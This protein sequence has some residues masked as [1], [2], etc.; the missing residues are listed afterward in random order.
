ME[1]DKENS[2]PSLRNAESLQPENVFKSAEVLKYAVAADFIPTLKKCVNDNAA[3]S[4][5]QQAFANGKVKTITDMQ[6]LTPLHIVVHRNYLLSTGWL[7]DHGAD[8]SASEDL[9]FTPLMVAAGSG[10]EEALKTVL[11]KCQGIV[12]VDARSTEGLT[13][14]HLACTNGHANCLEAL[15]SVGGAEG[16]SKC[17]RGDTPMHMSASRGFTSC[18]KILLVRI[19]SVCRP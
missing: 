16:I 6:G 11:R 1:I 19:C 14:V 13:A 17:V 10:S 15:L 3:L 4:L 12:D 8:V 7:L 18:V 2:M 9:G 5:C